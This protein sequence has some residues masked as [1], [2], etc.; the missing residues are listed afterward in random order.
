MLFVGYKLPGKRVR[1]KARRIRLK[2]GADIVASSDLYCLEQVPES[3]SNNSCYL[4]GMT[5]EYVCSTQAIAPEMTKQHQQA[6]SRAT[7]PLDRCTENH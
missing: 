2:C 6:V 3:V 4:G 1:G 7:V 5:H